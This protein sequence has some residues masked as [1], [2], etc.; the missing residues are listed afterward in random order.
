VRIGCLVFFAFACDSPSSPSDAGRDAGAIDG[1]ATDAGR[2]AGSDAGSCGGDGD[3]PSDRACV[4][5]ACVLCTG[6]PSESCEGATGV[7]TDACG[8]RTTRECAVCRRGLCCAAPDLAM[9]YPLPRG[10]QYVWWRFGFPS[11]FEIEHTICIHNDPGTSV[12]LYFQMYQGE[13]DDIG[14]Y[15]GLQTNVSGLGG[16]G[17]IFSRWLSRD[18]GDTR[19]ASG[20][21]A[22][23]SGSEGDFVSVRAPFEW[24]VGC[25]TFHLLRRAEDGDS[26][27]FDLSIR[28]E[29]GTTTDL[30]G[31]RFERR[32]RMTRATIEDGGGTWTEVYSGAT[33]V[34]DI[35][36]WHVDVAPL[37]DGDL[38]PISATA[39]YSEL[40]NS[41][42]W[43]EP[44]PRVV[45]L[46]LGGDTPRC[47]AAGPLF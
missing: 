41:D 43:F 27:W 33:V 24:G 21:M 28:D 42:V 2:D 22:V 38:H 29:A 1:G 14:F 8:R 3:C 15:Y 31:L 6:T 47:T 4:G 18:L 11:F 13:I 44:G 46:E 7:S 32:D 35:P 5:G 12:G 23:S 36:Y 19:V 30:G 9:S 20:G 25:Y 40:P 39:D 16:K 10:I 37:A 26:D 34:A 45:H 17:A